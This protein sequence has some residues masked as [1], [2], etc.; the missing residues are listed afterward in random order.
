[1][2]WNAVTGAVIGAIVGGA[3]FAFT[4]RHSAVECW[5]RRRAGRAPPAATPPGPRRSASSRSWS[6]RLAA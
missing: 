4:G 1:M 5:S 2:I 3:A 6:S